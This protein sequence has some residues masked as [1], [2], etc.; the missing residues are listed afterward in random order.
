MTAP[1]PPPS[2]RELLEQERLEPPPKRARN[3]GQCELILGPM[4]AGKT[5]LLMQR[6]Q[7]MLLGGE[8]CVVVK[9][10]KDTRYE[11]G[12]SLRTHAGLSLAASEGGLEVV[13]ATALRGLD[14][15]SQGFVAVDEGQFF[16]DLPAAVDGWMRE[17]RG[18]VV[19][20]L[21]G[22]FRRRPF[23][24]IGEV[25]PLAAHVSKLTAICMLCPRAE[26]AFP[27][28]APYTLRT[29]E[30]EDVELIGAKDKYQAACLGCYLAVMENRGRKPIVCD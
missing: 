26:G 15:G 10:S 7:R 28:D 12:P 8:R 23:G 18:V 20:A 30:S 29:D 16:E 22:D 3:L 4:Y 24:R 13:E 11:R 25:I 1:P 17:G 19:A 27:A 21:D 5:T 6:V 9:H 14:L 2:Y